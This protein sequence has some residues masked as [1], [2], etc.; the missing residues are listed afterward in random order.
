MAMAILLSLTADRLGLR[1]EEQSRSVSCSTDTCAKWLINSRFI[2]GWETM[3]SDVRGRYGAA[4]RETA[5]CSLINAA[6]WAKELEL[7]TRITEA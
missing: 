3:G 6:V 4:H 5:V 7:D 2:C 1:D